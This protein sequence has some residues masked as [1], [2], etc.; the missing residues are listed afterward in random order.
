MSIRIEDHRRAPGTSRTSAPPA[1]QPLQK[2]LAAVVFVVGALLVGCS[3]GSKTNTARAST[4]MVVPVAVATVERRDVP[5][6]MKGLGTVTA[7]NTV[8]V[9]SRV[10]GQLAQISFKEGQHVKKGELL[11]VIDPRPFQV[12]LDQARGNLFRDQ[13]QLKDA[14]LNY[15]RFKSLLDDSG[16]VSRQ[17]VDTQR[18]SAQQL[19]GAVRADQAQI[20]SA[21]LNLVYTRISA[22]IDGRIGLRLVDVGNMVHAADTNPLLVITELQPIAVLFTLPEDQLQTVS[23]HM[24]QS[25]LAVEA[26]S[27]DDQTK[28]ATGKLLTIDNQ[29]DPTTGTGRLKAMFDNPDDSLWPNQ[30]VNVRLLLETHKGSVVLPSVAV[31]TGPEGSYVFTVKPDKTVAVSPVTV[32]FT[33]NNVA[34]IASGVAPGD[35]VVV[36]GQDKLKNGSKVDPHASSGT[37]NHPAQPAAGQSAPGQSSST[38]AP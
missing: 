36:D 26:Y 7:S 12:A 11:A 2:L 31:Q 38:G 9:R 6:Y 24:H 23:Q 34:S 19:E 29:I 20:D 13:A 21:K 3:A 35:V 14:E 4:Q 32:S 10:D 15:E 27:A 18:A 33:Q 16:A 25:T 17:Q 8:S 1:G 37:G 5:V 28:L 22:P 30:F